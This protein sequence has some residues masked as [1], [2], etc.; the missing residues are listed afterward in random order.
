MDDSPLTARGIREP[1]HVEEPGG[2]IGPRGAQ[3]HVVG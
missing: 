2:G 1:A 3:Q